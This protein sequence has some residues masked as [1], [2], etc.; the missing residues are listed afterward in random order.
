MA[1]V[2]F[3]AL[4]RDVVVYG[5]MGGLSKSANLL[6]LP[7][8]TRQFST[9]EY[10]VVDIVAVFTS[11]L[12]LFIALSLES[13]IA[14]FWFEA[15]EEKQPQL[16]SSVL[17]FIL[18]LG[19]VL[20]TLAW[21]AADPLASLMLDDSS[22]GPYILLGSMAALSSA[23][24]H[25]PQI[26]LRMQR[27]IG[28]YTVV[29][30]AQSL[31]FAGLA[32][33][34]VAYWNAGVEGVFVGQVLGY[35]AALFI[36]LFFVRSLVTPRLS[37]G[38]LDASLRYS[39]PLVP[40][41]MVSK[42]NRYADRFILLAFLA[43]SQVGV[44]ASAARL[45]LV[46]NLLV[47]ISRKAWEPHA[48]ALIDEEEGARNDFYRRALNYYVGALFS[49]A[50]V[51]SAYAPE[52]LGLLVP[53]EYVA[54]YVVIPWLVGA[55]VINGS[56]QFT[57]L[58]ILISKQTIGNSVAAWSGAIV[59]IGIGLM[60][61]PQIGIWGAA[62]GSFVAAVIFTSMLY[63]FS[64][65]LVESLSFDVGSAAAVLS[66]YVLACVVFIASFEK[67]GGGTPSLVIRTSVL[68]LALLGVS[69][70]SFD[71]SARR[72][73][74]SLLASPATAVKSLLQGE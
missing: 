39:L 27:R 23:L 16:V 3:R 60:L 62:I 9:E 1:N 49:V 22:A 41:V 5:L 66:I 12:T 52:F 38:W 74:R 70:L 69:L 31:G 47:D 48:V 13:A 63:R 56:G 24:L 15:D 34:L 36:G 26:V 53:R 68:I 37:L 17:V 46:V 11:V 67:L 54:G 18:V 4:G 33:L 73:A 42:I 51:M 2:S 28:A 20:V 50:L 6:L 25:V 7:F 59:N 21:V 35:S 61:I 64:R 8:L 29:S 55:R 72:T 32:I 45:A 71:A 58:G 14:R 10:G 19:G 57:N 30:I 65:E 43:L 44:F 40:A